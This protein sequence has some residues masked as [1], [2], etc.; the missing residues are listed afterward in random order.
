MCK[1]FIGMLVNGVAVVQV[2][3]IGAVQHESFQT[4]F[5]G[6]SYASGGEV[7]L[8]GVL[9]DAVE[10]ISGGVWLVGIREDQPARTP[11]LTD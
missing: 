3:D 2:E 9:G 5:Q 1:L 6:L 7:E 4:G 8:V 10:V 11:S